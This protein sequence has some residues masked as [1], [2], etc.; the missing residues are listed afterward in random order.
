MALAEQFDQYDKHQKV[1]ARKHNEHA[2]GS[3]IDSFSEIIGAQRASRKSSGCDRGKRRRTPH[4]KAKKI[5]DEYADDVIGN[6]C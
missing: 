1:S 2:K 5:C 4:Y 6:N 3:C